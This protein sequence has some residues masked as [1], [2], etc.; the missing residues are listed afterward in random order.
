M[1]RLG[2]EQC[3]FLATVTGN[4]R[5]FPGF[6]S[7]QTAECRQ[8]LIAGQVP[9]RVVVLLEVIEVGQHEGQQAVVPAT[10]AQ[11]D[12]ERLSKIAMVVQARQAV[13]GGQVLQPAVLETECLDVPFQAEQGLFLIY[14]SINLSGL[15]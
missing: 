9:Q 1:A 12:L 10:A 8:Q 4:D 14:E 5:G 15:L 3:E 7:D 11:L 6:A 13:A 2:N